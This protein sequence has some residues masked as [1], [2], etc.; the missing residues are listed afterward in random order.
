MAVSD[1][2]IERL[3]S[4]VMMT[5]ASSGGASIYIN[6]GKYLSITMGDRHL[7]W[8][9]H[10]DGRTI[11]QIKSKIRDALAAEGF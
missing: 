7:C 10:E 2:E 4:T 1:D 9:N 6:G 3:A 8:L 5:C 11:Q